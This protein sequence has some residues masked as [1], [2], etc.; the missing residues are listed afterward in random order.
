MA[1][2]ASL[3]DE[4]PTV[5]PDAF[6]D[7]EQP[8]SAQLPNAEGLKA[9]WMLASVTF[10]SSDHMACG[11]K[12]QKQCAWAALRASYLHSPLELRSERQPCPPLRPV[13]PSK[14]LEA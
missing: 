4:W 11:L 12:M 1:I 7:Q 8:A 5:A 6:K 10:A 14:I 2:L 3:L 9:S 13:R